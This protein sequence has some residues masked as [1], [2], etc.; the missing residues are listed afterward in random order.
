VSYQYKTN[1]IQLRANIEDE[2]NDILK[3]LHEATGKAKGCLI[4]EMLKESVMFQ[5]AKSL[6]E[7]L[8]EEHIAKLRKE[9]NI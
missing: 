2:T 8:K 1:K 5:K 6:K 3:I 9:L 4:D 7:I